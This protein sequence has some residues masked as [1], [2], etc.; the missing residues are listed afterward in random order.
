[1]TTY[2]LRICY[3]KYESCCSYDCFACVAYPGYVMK[4]EPIKNIPE[5]PV[6]LFDNTDEHGIDL[7]VRR[8]LQ[9]PSVFREETT[10]FR[11]KLD[12]SLFPCVQP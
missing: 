8:V 7:S 2:S 4:I 3:A 9:A 10:F 6:P 1:M 11:R 12:L 5:R